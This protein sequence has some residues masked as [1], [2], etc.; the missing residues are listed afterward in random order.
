MAALPEGRVAVGSC[1]SPEGGASVSVF[2]M[3]MADGESPRTGTQGPAVQAPRTLLHMQEECVAS[4][5]CWLP[6]RLAR[7]H[8]CMREML[9]SGP[10]WWQQACSTQLCGPVWRAMGP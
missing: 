1:K 10:C 7:L 5:M 3:G 2:E 8:A 9:C 6:T 4:Y